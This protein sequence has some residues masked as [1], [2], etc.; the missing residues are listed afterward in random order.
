MYPIGVKYSKTP[1]EHRQSKTSDIAKF[2][3]V[4][5]WLN[6]VQI[7]AKFHDYNEFTYY[8]NNFE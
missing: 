2:C 7:L 1:Y 4:T 8:F 5:Y 3:G 6:S